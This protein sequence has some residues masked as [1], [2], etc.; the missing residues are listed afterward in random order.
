MAEAKI[1]QALHGMRVPIDSVS[2]DPN[3]VRK[4]DEAQLSK[5]KGALSI[6]GQVSPIV[7][8]KSTNVIRKGNATWQ[9][10]KELGWTE[11]AVVYVDMD[12]TTARAYAIADNRLSELSEWDMEGLSESLKLL[13]EADYDLGSLG[14]DCDELLVLKDWK[15]EVLAVDV[16]EGEVPSLPEKAASRIGDLWLLGGHRVL[17]GDSTKAG[18]AGRLMGGKDADFVFTSPPYN[19]GVVYG[20]HDDSPRK[21]KQYSQFIS[22]VVRNCAILLSG[23]RFLAWNVGTSP[24]TH[25]AKQHVLIEELGFTYQRM[26]VWQ[27]V[28]A[29][30]P[31]FYNTR[32]NPIARQFTPNYTHEIVLLFSLGDVEKGE[33]VVFDDTL[34]NDVFTIHQPLATVDVPNDPLANRTG[35]QQNLDRRSR[36]VHPA[37]YPVKLPSAFISHLADVDAIVFDPF[38]GSGTTLIAAEQLGRK[39]YGL[40]ISPQYVDVIVKRWQEF[41]KRDATLEGTDNTFVAIAAERGISCESS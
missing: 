37:P 18:D 11:I 22:A 5:L 2:L 30:V 21:W 28:G 23:G 26:T 29:P 10:A 35:A 3:N 41:T 16:V 8:Q 24:K 32:K 33:P 25:H 36:K 31:L 1:V 9:A 12:D 34:E 13:E 39:C 14:W 38:L 20:K 40:E 6:Y 27:K 4:H 19:V 17:C 15:P 7:V